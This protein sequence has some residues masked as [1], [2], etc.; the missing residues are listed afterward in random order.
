V[1]VNKYFN[2]EKR[3]WGRQKEERRE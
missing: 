1:E 3:Y 2:E